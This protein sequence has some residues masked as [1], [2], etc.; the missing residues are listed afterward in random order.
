M[1][2]H[3]FRASRP[4]TPPR[5]PLLAADCPRPDFDLP[6]MRPALAALLLL[7]FTAALAAPVALA[8]I[9]PGPLAA[10]AA[11][12][13]ILGVTVE[14]AG[15]EATRAVVL[16]A[17]GL[18]VGQNVTMPGDAA[19]S[20]AIRAV[21][22]LGQFNDVRITEDRRVDGGVFLSI[23][24]DEAER[25][26]DYRFEGVPKK[27]RDDLRKKLPFI[28]GARL[29][30]GDLA[31]AEQ[32][33]EEFYQEKGFVL[34][35]ATATTAPAPD[36]G[37]VV[38]VG[39]DRGA[40]V[41]VGQLAIQGNER[42]SDR[43][44]RKR[45]KNT[46]EDTWWRFWKRASYSPEKFEEDLASVVTFY[47]ERGYYDARVVRDTA[48]LSTSGKPE[49]VVSFTVHEGPRYR[50]RDVT[51]EGNTVLTDAQLT[52]ALGLGEGDV[53]NRTRFEQNL[54]G[55]KQQS[56]IGGLYMNQGYMRFNVEPQIRVAPGDSLDL[57]FDVFEGD[58][59]SYGS[60]SIAGNDK[61]KEHVIRRELYT[62]PGQTFSREA[63][64]ESIRRLSQL[65]YFNQESLSTGPTTNIDDEN[66]RVD[67][68]FTVEEVGGDQLELSGTYG[69]IGLILQLG[70][71]FNN[72]SA[73]N[74]FNGSAW[75][76]LPMGDGQQLSLRVQTAGLSYQNYSVSFT[77]P[78]FRGRPTPIGFSLNLYRLDLSRSERNVE[79]SQYLTNFA[80][81][82]FFNQRLKWPD[83]K[84]DLGSSVNYRYYRVDRAYLDLP[85]GVNH[86]LTLEETIRRNSQDH[87]VFP[88]RGSLAEF[89]VE[90]A[91]PVPGFIQYHK[92]N[93]KTAWNAPLSNRFTFGF[94]T[95]YGYIGSFTG[96]DVRFQRFLVGGSPFE[97]Q[98]VGS[99]NFGKE[100][101]FTR[102][103]PYRALGPRRE[104]EPVGGRI[105][106]KY[107][108]EV[109][110][111]AIQSP[112]LQAVP[113]LFADAVNTWDGFSTYNPAQLYRSAG[114]GVRLFLP[115]LGMIELA[116]GYGF[117]RFPAFGDD[118]G[119]P[120]WRFQFTIGQ[121]FNQ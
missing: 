19:L 73:Q 93:F 94:T 82:V 41:E 98:G 84:F 38:T 59:Y 77:E 76:P 80:S 63:I 79:K 100:I 26:S 110:W 1:S 50:V 34:A 35:N 29:A 120:K 90:V 113:Y 55:N 48:F 88:R 14:G 96:D 43:A 44:L 54:Y 78:W 118:D 65:N 81:R 24:V 36:G 121:G 20:D 117:D 89:S 17:S 39:V 12:V 74:L 57:A 114:T 66:K 11:P 69:S 101:I 107:T 4:E 95:T 2:L 72:F 52:T 115:I 40:R 47:N 18:R 109:R 112:Q 97:A 67:L 83:D 22:R 8:Q 104:N 21:Y 9:A 105:L 23:H 62:I 27:D 91:P 28:K 42:V 102:S 16:Q 51:W 116:Y 33:S 56:D 86:E 92:W 6:R 85:Q 30:Q 3:G 45:L 37:V 108:S 75:R 53:F 87:P 71:T 61:T 46:K 111:N 7:T 10:G 60:V 13:Q 119:V 64:T 32:V 58:V 49:M 70:V 99:Q 106:N 5:A 103:Y 68:G 15:T 31:R 25:L